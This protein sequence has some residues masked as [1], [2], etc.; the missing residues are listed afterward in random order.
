M[1]PGRFP[2]HI[3]HACL[4]LAVSLGSAGCSSTSPSARP[5]SPAPSPSV[6]EPTAG[7]ASERLADVRRAI[8]RGDAL[9]P[10]SFL[11]RGEKQANAYVR[12]ILLPWLQ[13]RASVVNQAIDQYGLT[14]NGQ[15]QRTEAEA[16]LMFGD[17]VTRLLDDFAVASGELDELAIEPALRKQ[18]RDSVDV[19]TNVRFQGLTS[20]SA[21]DA[22]DP[23]VAAFAAACGT[24]RD[25]TYLRLDV[26]RR[27]P[28][29]GRQS[30]PC[31]FSGTLTVA[32]ASL[33]LSSAPS[34][35]ATADVLSVED[36]EVASLR[37][38][39]KRD[40][41]ID[42][43]LSWPVSIRGW[44]HASAIPL[45][46]RRSVD[47][48]KGHLWLPQGTRGFA[49]STGRGRATFARPKAAE[50]AWPSIEIPISCDDIGLAVVNNQEN[51]NMT[52]LALGTIE[53]FTRANGERLATIDTNPFI[54]VSVLDGQGGW[55]RLRHDLTADDDLRT[56]PYLPWSFDAWINLPRSEL[57]KREM[58]LLVGR[59][60]TPPPSHRA[61]AALPLRDR[62]ATSAPPI[63]HLAVGAPL[64]IGRSLR[65][66]V[67]VRVPGV[68]P[69]GGGR[70]IWVAEADLASGAK[71][72][73]P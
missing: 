54:N 49:W 38:P 61:I 8:E 9:T 55:S 19:M 48:H 63:G 73:T 4:G 3:R 69:G 65:G 72:W 58:G 57:K 41:S 71:P 7:K 1:T 35:E 44:M 43:T 11:E 46:L 25:W 17:A 21:I 39:E 10:P 6:A 40:G 36:V 56:S 15:D 29:P 59:D 50:A 47:I 67:A 14:R 2:R 62:A 51:S 45:V 12:H 31:N 33:T 26:P 37:L 68:F 5:V 23:A 22:K 66:L 52:L 28:M 60:A 32:H 64:R 24:R 42:V 70:D 18:L 53:L 27:P 16:M 20:C 34:P 13:T 30:G